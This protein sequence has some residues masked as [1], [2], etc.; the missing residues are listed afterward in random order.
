MAKKQ[1]EDPTMHKVRKLIADSG[2]SQHEIG[3]AMGYP[4]ETA[5]QS[6]FQFTKSG[7]PRIGTLRRFAKAMGVKLESLL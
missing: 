3:L 2:K 4:E 6:V 1:A 7:D 5:R